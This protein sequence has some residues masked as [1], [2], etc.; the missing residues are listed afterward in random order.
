MLSRRLWQ[1]QLDKVKTPPHA[2]KSNKKWCTLI[3]RRFEAM[4]WKYVTKD[5]SLGSKLV[6]RTTSRQVSICMSEDGELPLPWISYLADF[7]FQTSCRKAGCPCKG[8]EAYSQKAF[9]FIKLQCLFTE[10]IRQLEGANLRPRAAIL[11]GRCGSHLRLTV[12]V[13]MLSWST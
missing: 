12:P 11:G 7:L 2:F 10:G 13:E 6:L 4:L 5:Y 8:I 1:F 9:H 3:C